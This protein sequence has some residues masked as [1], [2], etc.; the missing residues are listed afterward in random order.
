M[1][2]LSYSSAILGLLP[3]FIFLDSKITA[4][5][6]HS[7]EIKRCL[8]LARKAVTN[9]DR[10][11]KSRVIT[12]LIKVHLVKAIA[13]P[14]VLYRYEIWTIKKLRDKELMFSNCD[15]GEDS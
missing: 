9:L 1:F 7:L 13:F 4:D 8:L 11:L 12:L 5:G 3:V 15:V 14:V 6:D 2:S 10:V